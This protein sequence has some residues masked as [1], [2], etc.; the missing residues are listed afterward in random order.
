VAANVA[1]IRVF[2]AADEERTVV[3]LSTLRGD[4]IGPD[5]NA[6]T[7]AWSSAPATAI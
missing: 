7:V 4:L 1:G 3:R 2:T 6:H 5:I